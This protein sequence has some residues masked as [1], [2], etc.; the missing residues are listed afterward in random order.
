MP[1]GTSAKAA[2][3]FITDMPGPFRNG[4]PPLGRA[5]AHRDAVICGQ[6]DRVVLLQDWGHHCPRKQLLVVVP[7]V[8]PVGLLWSRH[9]P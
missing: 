9:V 4:A 8:G 7:V 2:S 3:D 5:R 1:F 6:H